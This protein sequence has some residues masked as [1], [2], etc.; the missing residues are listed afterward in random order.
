MTQTLK[1]NIW[2]IWKEERKEKIEKLNS[3]IGG[4]KRKKD[5]AK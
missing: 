5:I 2:N 1:T 4:K 3:I